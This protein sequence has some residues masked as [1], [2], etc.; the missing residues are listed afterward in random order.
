QVE[1][2]RQCLRHDATRRTPLVVRLDPSQLPILIYA[3]SGEQDLAH[4]K[5]ELNNQVAPILQSAG[6]VASAAAT[7][8]LD[9]AIIVDVDPARLQAY[10]LS[11]SDVSRRIVQENLDQ[12]AGIAREGQTE[13]TIRSLGYFRNPKEIA[14]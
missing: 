9:R 14:A 2:A 3:V 6:G 12:P 1:R 13:Y 4:L 8:G 5:A 10:H 11:L 7:G